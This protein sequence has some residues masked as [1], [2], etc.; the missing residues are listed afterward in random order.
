MHVA[1]HRHA[2]HPP[3][4][5]IVHRRTAGELKA[6]TL[7]ES[8]DDT[9]WAAVC[10]NSRCFSEQVWAVADAQRF[11]FKWGI[12]ASASNWDGTRSAKSRQRSLG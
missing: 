2:W 6:L 9:V 10:V 1:H 3:P 7:A 12:G 4:P 5:D 11:P 8:P